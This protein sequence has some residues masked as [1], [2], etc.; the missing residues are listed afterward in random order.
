MVRAKSNPPPTENSNKILLL[1]PLLV[2]EMSNLCRV[3]SRWR[4]VVS[5]LKCLFILE[6]MNP[7]RNVMSFCLL[8]FEV[9]SLRVQILMK[10]KKRSGDHHIR[11]KI[12]TKLQ[13]QHTV[14]CWDP[15]WFESPNSCHKPS[16]QHIQHQFKHLLPW[17]KKAM[18]LF[19]PNHWVSK[20]G[21]S[22]NTR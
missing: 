20:P 2:L 18:S 10:G 21:W 13:Q 9:T 16:A 4:A 6:R 17:E 12:H 8:N 14:H 22:L 19:K 5:N 11:T 1:S 15:F 7:Q 3:W